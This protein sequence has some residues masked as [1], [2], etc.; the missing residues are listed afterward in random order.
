KAGA[1]SWDDGSPRPYPG[2]IASDWRRAV[3]WAET[4]TSGGAWAELYA[5]HIAP[6]Q[7]VDGAELKERVRLLPFD[8][9]ERLSEIGVKQAGQIA[10]LSLAQFA[11]GG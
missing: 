11:G 6:L 2:N 8:I 4:N 3:E 7:S 1:G 9:K 5:K 10:R